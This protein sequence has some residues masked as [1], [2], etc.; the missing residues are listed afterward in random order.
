VETTTTH[1]C[2]GCQQPYSPKSPGNLT[3]QKYCSK[4]CRAKHSVWVL[5][6][7][8]P[9]MSTGTIGAIGE[10]RVCV[11]LLTKGYEVFRAV[12]PSCSCD[13]LVYKEGVATRIEVRTA[14]RTKSGNVYH[15]NQHIRAET[16]AA[17][18]PDVIIYEPPLPM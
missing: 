8:Y 5:Q 13:L 2:K 4:K 3:R 17:V 16:L 9:G 7:P 10:L 1:I 12:S 15:P 6:R 11:D 14:Y 18:L